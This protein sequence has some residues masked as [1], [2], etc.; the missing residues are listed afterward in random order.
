MSRCN[1]LLKKQGAAYPRTCMLCGLGPCKYAE[2][3]SIVAVPVEPPAPIQLHTSF[4]PD[5]I[6]KG[7]R[8]LA[9]TIENGQVENMPVITTCLV[10]LGHTRSKLEADGSKTLYYDTKYYGFGERCDTFTT[11]GLAATFLSK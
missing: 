10:M 4:E 5:D 6:V 3:G 2:L 1:N 7:L 9:D 11:R 8:Q